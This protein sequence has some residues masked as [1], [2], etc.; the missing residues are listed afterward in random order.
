M[1]VTTNDADGEVLVHL[2]SGNY[3]DRFK[4]YVAHLREWRQ[5]FA[6]L[7][8]VDL[9]YDRQI[10]VNPD[11][12]GTAKQPA[13]SAK[14]AK[15]AIAAGV[16]PAALVT[17]IPVAHTAATNPAPKP[18]KDPISLAVGK[19]QATTASRVPSK[20]DS[21][22]VSRWHKRW[23]P[24]K[25]ATAANHQPAASAKAQIASSSQKPSPAIKKGPQSQ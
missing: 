2:G 23:T 3:L 7:E 25:Q 9:R 4:V 11:L 8:S 5:Q 18:H 15:A 12:R 10:V 17:K 22:K 24:K 14:A 1:K 6:K 19:T 13:L 20:K 21:Q 16:K